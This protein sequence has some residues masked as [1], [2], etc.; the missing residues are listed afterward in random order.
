MSDFLFDSPWW[1]PLAIAALGMGVWWSGNKRIDRTTKL[2]GG[3][4]F[5]AAIALFLTSWFVDTDKE[6][7]EKRTRELVQGVASKDWKTVESIL[8]P[9]TSL[10]TIGRRTAYYTDRE[11][12]LSAARSASEGYGIDT[13]TI[14]HMETRQTDTLI[15]ISITVFTT[16]NIT[17]QPFR[18]DWQLDWNQIGQDWRLTRITLVKLGMGETPPQLPAVR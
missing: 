4:I 3:A 8:D 12:I 17:G 13:A 7:A 9:K 16:Q 11:Q 15:T 18:S 5:A 1:M 2:V 6:R 14:T 10:G